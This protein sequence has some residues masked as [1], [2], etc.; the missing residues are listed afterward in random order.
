MGS[1]DGVGIL[2]GVFAEAT[3]NRDSSRRVDTGL[4]CLITFSVLP[5][6]DEPRGRGIFDLLLMLLAVL[7]ISMLSLEEYINDTG[8]ET[9]VTDWSEARGD[10]LL[11]YAEITL[12]VSLRFFRTPPPGEGINGEDLAAVSNIAAKPLTLLAIGLTSTRPLSGG[13]GVFLGGLAHG[14]LFACPLFL[15]RTACGW[16]RILRAGRELFWLSNSCLSN[17]V[18][19]SM[20]DPRHGI[21]ERK[22]SATPSIWSET[23]LSRM[24]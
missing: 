14:V 1:R 10:G 7:V 2:E 8:V 19:R 18:R 6:L 17:S 9:E 22:K 13:L 5:V 15:V 16:E 24:D 11:V 21:L 12:A 4:V 20:T 23:S 3:E